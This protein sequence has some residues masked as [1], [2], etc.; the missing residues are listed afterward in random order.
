MIRLILYKIIHKYDY[1]IIFEQFMK[2]IATKFRQ[3]TQNSIFFNIFALKYYLAL[4][5]TNP[6]PIPKSAKIKTHIKPEIVKF[7][8]LW[9]LKLFK[10]KE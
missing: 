9:I 10:R 7:F 5:F 6:N 2:L 3:L 4:I 8:L 1:K